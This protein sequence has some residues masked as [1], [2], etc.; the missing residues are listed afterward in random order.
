MKED[1]LTSQKASNALSKMR[2]KACTL[3]E[4]E[5]T[6]EQMDEL[7]AATGN[8]NF[9]DRNKTYYITKFNENNYEIIS[10]INSEEITERWLEISDLYLG[11]VFCDMEMLEYILKLAKEEGITNVHIAGDLCAGHPSYKKQDL[12]L[13]AKTAQEQADIA[14]K[15]FSKFPEFKYYCINGERD[16][17][18]EKG[19]SI[20]PIVL[21]QRALNEKGIDFHHI[22]E[23][24]ANLVIDG[25]VKRIQHGTGRLAYTKS[26]KIEKEMWQQFENMSDNVIIKNRNYN[27][28]F[29][30]FGHYH[31]NCLQRL[32]GIM[33]TS[34]AGMVMDDKGVL[35]ENTSY[36]S[37]KFSTAVIKN[38]KVVRFVTE[39]ITNPKNVTM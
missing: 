5:L 3:E 35:N 1:F 28:C 16:L 9:N 23:M 12:Y 14:I 18:F 11:S 17:S 8:I 6:Q 27:I 21:V 13:T 33:I 32:G 4:L 2:A 34:T 7:I 10:F 36:P 30:Q 31:V 24:V 15:L 20:N 22:N 38:G 19:D 39:S 37:A 26:Y 25:V 29:V